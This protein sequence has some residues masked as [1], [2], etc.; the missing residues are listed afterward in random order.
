MNK[1]TEIIIGT[2][3]QGKYK[4]I[5]DLLPSNIKKHSPKYNI[6]MRDDKSYP[7]IVVDHS[8]P[9]PRL[10][11]TRRFKRTKEVEVFGPFAVGS[12][13]SDVLKIINKLM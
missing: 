7:Y 3:N 2:N 6:R 4:E 1:I 8:E 10:K 11:Y 9:F 13:V 12:R 5:S